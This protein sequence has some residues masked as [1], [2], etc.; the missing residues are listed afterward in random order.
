MM[1]KWGLLPWIFSYLVYFGSAN[2]PARATPNSEA[3]CT[4][5]TENGIRNVVIK[6]QHRLQFVEIKVHTSTEIDIALR[7]AQARKFYKVARQMSPKMSTVPPYNFLKAVSETAVDKKIST[8]WIQ[9]EP[10]NSALYQ[11]IIPDASFDSVSYQD[12]RKVIGTLNK[13]CQGKATFELPSEQQFVYLARLFYNQVQTGQLKSCDTLR[14]EEKS[15]TS[16]TVK[17]V[18]GYQWQI[19]NSKCQSFDYSCDEKMYVKKGGSDKS[20]NATE[21]MPE[22]RDRISPAKRNPNTTVRLVLADFKE[23]DFQ[24][25]FSDA[26]ANVNKLTHELAQEKLKTEKLVQ[27]RGQL[28]VQVTELNEGLAQKQGDVQRLT[29]GNTQIS[30]ELTR[31]NKKLARKLLEVKQLT[32]K[33]AQLNE[34]V[35]EANQEL[36][37]KRVEITQ[38]NEEL[39]QVKRE[40]AE[41]NEELA[42][43]RV[44]ITQLNNELTQAQT[45]ADEL[46]RE[47]ALKRVEI[48]QLNKELTQ[49][50]IKITQFNEKLARKEKR[51]QQLVQNNAQLH[52]ELTFTTAEPDK[53]HEDVQK[54]AVIIKHDALLFKQATGSSGREERFMQIYFVMKPTINNRIPV[55]FAPN[56]KGKPDGWL[57]Q[58]SYVE[59]NT[60]QMLKPE[61]QPGRKRFKVFKTQYCAE[62]GWD[63]PKCQYQELGAEP[64]RFEPKVAEQNILIP[65]FEKGNNSYQGGF[66]QIYEDK[67][68]RVK[69]A[70]QPRKDK[71]QLGYDIVFAVDSTRGMG[72]YFLPIAETIQKF[73]EYVKNRTQNG[74]IGGGTENE[75]PLRMGVLFYRDR[76]VWPNPPCSMDYL[77][78]WGQEL[79][80]DIQ[81]VI[82]AFQTETEATCRSEDVPEAVLDGLNRVIVDTEW[83]DNSFRAIILV[84]DASP[85][86]TSDS[87]YGKNPMQLNTSGILKDAE[88]K[89]IRFLTFKL[90]DDDQAFEELAVAAI[91]DSNIGRYAVIP[92]SD[93]SAFKTN[94]EETMKKEW[95]VLEKSVAIV[96]DALTTPYANR[97]SKIDVTSYSVRQ[98]YGLTPYEALIIE[99]GSPDINLD[100][101]QRIPQ[102]VK[103]WIPRKIEGKLAISEYLFLNKHQLTKFTGRIEE[104]ASAFIIGEIDGSDAF[105]RS[106]R[107]SIASQLNLSVNDVFGSGSNLSHILAAA[108]ILPLK[109][110]LLS[111]SPEEYQTWK[112]A[113]YE[114]LNRILSEKA[115]YLRDFKGNPANFHYFGNKPFFYVP[116][117]FFP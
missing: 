40:V 33:N 95:A 42:R 67:S 79:T 83:Q 102:F 75:V 92:L 97:S 60:L 68:G 31:A 82:H 48:T 25:L 61:P 94:L 77:T 41:L 51:I 64:N 117:K 106:L 81:K 107:E 114:R 56:K 108:K 21:C 96:T 112:P 89:N 55:S 4:L 87:F 99:A 53:T 14:A 90:G 100:P 103:G 11:A 29:E 59:W 84:G 113:D 43:K 13:W 93:V 54:K 98:K 24:Q 111:F 49:A 12:A 62:Y 44:K 50:E 65:V 8:F 20:E 10:I 78:K 38:L 74:N 47:L 17:K 73:V 110:Q 71:R 63:E 7:K 30:E 5:K 16:R 58:G 3:V 69:P 1:K 101:S 46:N 27:E 32:G 52:Q 36:A 9:K 116:R 76:M 18:L 91:Q 28:T 19:T 23:K 2:S 57:E 34:E 70:V 80:N 88:E 15:D 115:E 37:Q 105:L 35:A 45:K 6:G 72:A 26:T 86:N 22:Y 85:H 109:T 39:I 104:L 66:I